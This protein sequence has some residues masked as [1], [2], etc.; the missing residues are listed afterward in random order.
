MTEFLT[1]DGSL[2]ITGLAAAILFSSGL[3]LYFA[4]KDDLKA[5]WKRDAGIVLMAL[6]FLWL[7]FIF[8]YDDL[9]AL[10]LGS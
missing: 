4:W 7:V 6:T 1:S 8:V 3:G 2:L 5:T 10:V 9:A